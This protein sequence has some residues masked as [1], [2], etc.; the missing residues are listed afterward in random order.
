MRQLLLLPVFVVLFFSSEAQ[1]KRIH[2][3]GRQLN[4][5]SV[6]KKM[7]VLQDSVEQ[8]IVKIEAVANQRNLETL[9]AI[10]KDREQQQK[11]NV[12]IMIG[13][14]LALAAALVM[15]LRKRKSVTK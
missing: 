5:D 3:A 14:G 4:K 15:G 1:I 11:K 2:P 9:A 10:Q 8:S 12:Y 6:V 7:Q 13:I